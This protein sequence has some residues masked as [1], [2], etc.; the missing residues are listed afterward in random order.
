ATAQ[1]GTRLGTG[2]GPGLPPAASTT[3]A[4]GPP[5]D[6]PPAD[7]P[8]ADGPSADAPAANAPERAPPASRPSPVPPPPTAPPSPP[9]TPL[10][11]ASRSPNRVSARRRSRTAEAVRSGGR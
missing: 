9:S 2:P 11:H 6:G 5:A 10:A 1:R 7:G 4:D 3:P 8:P